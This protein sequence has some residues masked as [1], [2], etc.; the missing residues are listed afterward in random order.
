MPFYDYCQC[1]EYL[2]CFITLKSKLEEDIYSV[3]K[4]MDHGQH[5]A[6]TL[7]FLNRISQ[8]IYQI[9]Q[10]L[11]PETHPCSTFST[12]HWNLIQRLQIKVRVPQQNLFSASDHS[13]LLPP[14]LSF[15][16]SLYRT[17]THTRMLA[18]TFV[19][20]TGTILCIQ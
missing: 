17:V 13:V 8:N 12:H 1:K 3:K 19:L 5:R 20:K 10:E 11:K 16:L 14:P 18:R 15:A 4:V 9:N 2:K 6:I 7:S